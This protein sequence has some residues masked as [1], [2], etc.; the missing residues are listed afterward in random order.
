MSDISEILPR[1]MQM[2][3]E[4]ALSDTPV[5][6]VLGA[7][8]VGK[9]TLARSLDM[10]RAYMDL[11]QEPYVD[12]ARTDPAG[13]V[14]GLPE[15]ITL[16]EVQRAPGLIPAIKNSVD[17]N[18]VPGRFLLTG[19]ANLLLLPKL[20]E[21]L[22]GRMEIIRL[23][24]LTESEK[25][26]NPGQYL[27]KFISGEL[28]PEIKPTDT[29]GDKGLLRRILAGGYP[30]AMKRNPSR[31]RT[32]HRQYLD[33]IMEKDVK[34]V[35]RV[36]DIDELF[37]LLQTL[38]SQ[39]GNLLNVSNLSR[40]LGISR[41][42]VDHYLAVL[43]RLYMIRLL[44]AWHN[45][46][47]KRL[48]KAAKVHIPD[49]GIAAYLMDL[50]EEDW[51]PERKR[52]GNLLESFIIQQIAAQASWTDPDLKLY[53]YRDKDGVEVDCVLSKG[54]KIW[55]IEVKASQSVDISDARGIR[56]LAEQAGSAF[57]SGTVFY[58]GSSI[59]PLTTNIL[60][61]PISK[62]WEY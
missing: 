58:S 20:T 44:P 29:E 56:R 35:A 49:S 59:L 39:T 19:S 41:A 40:D 55:G 8:Q 24:P 17:R 60:A 45:N 34:D 9:S 12:T 25:A 13:F 5:V 62:L 15:F 32:W 30:E 50:H 14:Q 2:A 37:R 47:A 4:T 36:Q 3:I 26:R 22:A 21:S 54:S 46:H 38:A 16:D 33:S 7:R 1:N 10:N 61:V 28:K 6:C 18:R 43:R 31:A 42:T 52:F 53:N 11:D 51:I 48:I 27:E 23:H 57:Q